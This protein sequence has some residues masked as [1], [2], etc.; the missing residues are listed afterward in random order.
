MQR[1][2]S[3]SSPGAR[4]ARGA[5]FGVC[6]ALAALAGCRPS[7]PSNA[8]G[9]S[10]ASS[11][12][13]DSGQQESVAAPTASGPSQPPGEKPA[14]GREVLRRMT[15]AYQNA[16]SYADKGKIR[17]VA[18]AGEQKLVDQSSDFSV[19]MVRPN[20]LCVVAYQA[21]MTCDG[22]KIRAA[23]FKMCPD[24]VLVK[25]AP[26]KLSASVITID[27][28]FAAALGD[29]GGPPPQLF[30]LLTKDPMNEFLLR[31]AQE[32]A[33]LEPGEID[34][35]ACYRVQITWPYGSG[36]FW[37]DQQ[38]YVLR[39]MVAPT[40]ELRSRLGRD[41][42]IDKLSL[43]AEFTGASLGGKVDPGAFEF[44]VPEGA[45]LV[46]LLVPRDTAQLLGK[47]APAFK[48]QDLDGKPVTPQTLAGRVAVLVFWTSNVDRF[49]QSMEMLRSVETV[50][51]P[52]QKNPNLAFY[53][54]CID[55]QQ[56]KTG[57]LVK[58]IEKADVRMPV[59][60]DTEQSF[61]VFNPADIPMLVVLDAKGTV[62]HFEVGHKPRLAEE[63]PRKL[64]RVLSG[65]DIYHELQKEYLER[66]E[67]FRA[68]ARAQNV[69][70]ETA[71]P[72][73]SPP[74]PAGRPRTTVHEVP[75]PATKIAPPSAPEHLKLSLLWKCTELK[76]PGNIL[77]SPPP[78]S[79]TGSA[80][81][82][83]GVP[84]AGPA[85]RLLVVENAR[86]IAE[87]G[88]D[89]KLIAVHP[90][91]LAAGE[92]IGHLRAAAAADGKRY[93]AAFLWMQQRCHV[94]DEKWSVVCHYPD[95]ALQHPHSGITD[96][97]LGDLE[98]RGNP[99]LLL[100]Y[101]GVVGVQ[102]ASI[103]GHFLWSNRQVFNVSRLAIGDPNPTGRQA[104]LVA[105]GSGWQLRC[106]TV[107]E[108]REAKS[109]CPGCGSARW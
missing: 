4:R 109:A 76:S 69:P 15:A 96:V 49:E 94:I 26:A 34:G 47:R 60:R 3:F 101:A 77:V 53:A 39:R 45:Q 75:L 100:G 86:S 46:D 54:V 5:T 23:A 9:G 58:E 24:Q 52:V 74:A 6:L 90:L 7:A 81:A 42:P 56:I 66:V 22:R 91:G 32:P 25:D 36:V 88:L 93:V 43:V 59:L 28:N 61:G 44:P 29:F 13:A 92:Y 63:L 68:E 98:G 95:N 17:L 97:E 16:S 107:R 40:D 73:E 14:T 51:Q 62:Q 70:D 8:G 38:T 67:R 103:D 85:P 99:K 33:L 30:L 57:D 72:P 50:R 10:G 79:A 80:S 20:K 11:A 105:D 82:L 84:P 104:L 108:Q 1:L 12:A 31:G 55:P 2:S 64:M 37:I 83:P 102:E 18:E 106:W 71:P 89:G 65:E 48:V 78:A 27:P 35:R 19:A 41:R 21:M 87:V